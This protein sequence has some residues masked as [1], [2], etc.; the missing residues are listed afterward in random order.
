MVRRIISGI[1]PTRLELQKLRKRLEITQRGRDLLEDK[2]NAMILEFFS[3]YGTF[4]ANRSRT[5]AILAEAYTAKQDAEMLEGAM[6]V[7]EAAYA[8]PEVLD[9]QMEEGSIMGTSIPIFSGGQLPSLEGR[10]PAGLPP[11][12]SLAISRF[13]RALFAILL[14]AEE[15]EGLRALVREIMMTRRKVNAM[16]RILIPALRSTASYI[17]EYLEEQER[18]ELYRRK[19]TAAKVG[20]GV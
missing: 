7:K 18:E 6:A 4:L 13:Q 9:L 20:R 8:V 19:I 2:L 16:D 14:T 17:E 5:D 10:T 3:R 12:I 15:E 11:P 1:R